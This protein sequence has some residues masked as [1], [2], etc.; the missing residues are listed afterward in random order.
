M[1][2]MLEKCPRCGSDKIIRG[3]PLQDSFGDLGMR[4]RQA[5]V[6]VHGNPQAWVFKETEYGKLSLDICGECGRAELQVSGFRALWE[7]QQS[8]SE[9]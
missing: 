2:K 3:V 9:G 7:R 8:A 1:R 5:E 4:S 6:K